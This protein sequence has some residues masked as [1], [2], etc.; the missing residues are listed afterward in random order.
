VGGRP[1]DPL[2]PDT[3]PALVELTSALRVLKGDTPLRALSERTGL[4]RATLS[5]MLAGTY[6]PRW[7]WIEGVVQAC[8]GDQDHI[9]QL[10][11]AAEREAE[12]PDWLSRRLEDVEKLLR[13]QQSRIDR[14][15]RIIN[16]QCS[17]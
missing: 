11:I 17:T 15:E 6:V 7:A 4:S 8:A 13:E 3:P 10:W 2:S 12:G 9:K 5:R 14:L 16:S 1:M